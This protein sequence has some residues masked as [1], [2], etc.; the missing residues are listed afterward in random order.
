MALGEESSLLVAGIHRGTIGLNKAEGH[1]N[2]QITLVG[3]GTFG[4][5]KSADKGKIAQ[6]RNLVVD[7]RGFVSHHT[8]CD[9]GFTV[10]GSDSGVDFRGVQNGELVVVTAF[11]LAFTV[12]HTGVIHCPSGKGLETHV[13]FSSDEVA[14]DGGIDFEVHT[15]VF[16]FV[17]NLTF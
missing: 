4:L 11:D 1:K 16:R 15:Q 3:S 8:A 9:N 13:D 7:G 12:N 10:T 6:D 5:E 17:K 2:Q 14:F